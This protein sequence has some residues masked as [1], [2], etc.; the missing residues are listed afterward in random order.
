MTCCVRKHIE[1]REHIKPSWAGKKGEIKGGLAPRRRKE[2]G[3]VLTFFF[4]KDSNFKSGS[5]RI[6]NWKKDLIATNRVKENQN[7]RNKCM[8]VVNF[9]CKFWKKLKTVFI[10]AHNASKQNFKFLGNFTKFKILGVFIPW[11]QTQAVTH[12]YT[13]DAAVALTFTK[14]PCLHLFRTGRRSKANKHLPPTRSRQGHI[15]RR[16][17]LLRKL[18]VQLNEYSELAGEAKLTVLHYRIPSHTAPI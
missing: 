17:E 13:S 5:K 2:N 7:T 11:G 3:E 10:F 1:G 9:V 6:W 8:H 16:I 4:W 12:G 14:G 18:L 15:C